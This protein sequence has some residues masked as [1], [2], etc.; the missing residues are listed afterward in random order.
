MHCCRSLS[1]RVSSCR[2]V[3]VWFLAAWAPKTGKAAGDPG[4]LWWNLDVRWLRRRPPEAPGGTLGR[5]A[6][7]AVGAALP[8]VGNAA[9]PP[10]PA[11]STSPCR[12]T[13][14]AAGGIACVLR[15]G[16]RLRHRWARSCRWRWVGGRAE[17]GRGHWPINHGRRPPVKGDSPTA[18][19]VTSEACR[20]CERASA[21]ERRGSTGRVA[22]NASGDVLAGH[23]GHDDRRAAGAPAGGRGGASRRRPGRRRR[24]RRPTRPTPRP[25]RARRRG[26][27]GGRRTGRRSPW[28]WRCRT[29]RR[30]RTGG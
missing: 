14:A 22:G 1:L 15:H 4:G 23:F 27:A 28:P 30:R 24:S 18:T 19:R 13:S 20:R 5:E 9:V 10:V 17:R 6:E 21:G 7:G 25:A 2:R 29:D 16:A 11:M 12:P 3:V 8:R 26:T